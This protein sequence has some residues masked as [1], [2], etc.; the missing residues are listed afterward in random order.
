MTD[1]TRYAARRL[2]RTEFLQL[3]GLRHRL[4]HWGPPDAAPLILLHGWADTADPFQFLVD[5]LPEYWSCAALDWRGFGGSDWSPGGYW[6]P[7]YY[8]D[9]DALLEQL[10]PAAPARIVGHSMG[11]RIALTYSGIRPERVARVASLEGVGMPRREPTEAPGRL[12]QW[13]KQ[14]REPPQHGGY[15]DYA[16]LAERLRSKHPR[17]P[18]ARARF[19]AESRAE[20][21]PAGGLRL[22]MDPAHHRVNPVLNRNEEDAACWRRI[23]APALLVLGGES[24]LTDRLGPDVGPGPIAACVRDLRVVTVP[25]AGH[26]LH[27]EQ[28]RA[29]AALLREFL[30]DP[31]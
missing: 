31:R 8:A 30:G 28:P 11:G 2:A 5:E 25:E 15:R 6:F 17:L 7:D 21:D 16:A 22:R 19:L 23:T 4:L 26:M 1:L 13:L 14:L 29:V 3:R 24:D 27:Y 10:S 18:P 9:L 12:A 20:P